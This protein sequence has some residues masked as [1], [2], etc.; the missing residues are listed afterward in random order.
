[1]TRPSV[2][3]ARARST[4]SSTLALGFRTRCR[5]SPGRA[6]PGG[7]SAE[8]S[9]VPGVEP[10]VV[11]V[12]AGGHEQNHRWDFVKDHVEPQQAVVEGLDLLHLADLQ[13]NMADLRP[14]GDGSVCNGVQPVRSSSSPS[15]VLDVERH[16]ATPATPP[17]R[18]DHGATPKL[19]RSQADLDSVAPPGPP[20]YR[21]SW[22]PWSEAPWSR[23][24]AWASGASDTASS[25]RRRHQHREAATARC[26]AGLDAVGRGIVAAQRR[27]AAGLRRPLRNWTRPSGRSSGRSPNKCS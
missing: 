10:D 16:R 11:V 25:P 12:A 9:A 1:M 3:P 15:E 7:G 4:T 21:A 17:G 23:Q 22:V 19:S 13:V 18:P 8:T 6:A 24:R 14:R 2:P 5:R 20:R 27:A 26:A